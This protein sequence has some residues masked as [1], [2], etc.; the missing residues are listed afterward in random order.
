MTDDLHDAIAQLKSSLESLERRAHALEQLS[1]LAPPVIIEAPKPACTNS[2]ILSATTAQGPG[3]L[4][5]LGRA[6]LGMAGAYLLRAL[7]ESTTFPRTAVVA[8]GIAYA[9][10]WLV[11]AT[12]MAAEAG[13]ARSAY[14]T[15]SALILIPVLWEVTLLFGTLSTALAAGPLAAYALFALALSWKGRWRNETGASITRQCGA[16]RGR[17]LPN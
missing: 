11:A 3:V 15:T 7:A 10:F 14:A 1:R 2:A 13:F 12:W 9:G 16:V 6:M 17:I 4:S 5:V 8:I